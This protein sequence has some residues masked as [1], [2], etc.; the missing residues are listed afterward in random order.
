MLS[1]TYDNTAT[2]VK[3]LSAAR[4]AALWIWRSR[5]PA[6]QGS[7]SLKISFTLNPEASTRIQ[8]HSRRSFLLL[9]F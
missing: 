7:Y 6:A 2:G 5:V 8:I 4:K 9:L 3:M 1:L